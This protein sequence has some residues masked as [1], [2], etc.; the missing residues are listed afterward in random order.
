[1][2]KITQIRNNFIDLEKRLKA[3]TEDAQNVN[4]TL[5][6]ESV[7][8]SS[9][10]EFSMAGPTW[11]IML[12]WQDR[13]SDKIDQL[14]AVL[15]A[16]NADIR[17]EPHVPPSRPRNIPVPGMLTPIRMP[18]VDEAALTHEISKAIEKE[19]FNA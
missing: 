12:L 13:L 10:K 9:P 2:N 19:D 14:Q 8:L 3:L 5:T 11:D 16:I 15:E 7:E 6:G 4:R 18:Q 17:P 1:M